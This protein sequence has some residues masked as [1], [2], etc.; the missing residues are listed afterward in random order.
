[1]PKKLNVA[2]MKDFLFLHVE[3]IVLG[4]C[5]FLAL[6]VGFMSM[7]RALSAGTD[8][9]GIPFAEALKRRHDQIA[10]GIRGASAKPLPA[11][12]EAKLK[13]PFYDWEY[14]ESKFGSSLYLWVPDFAND[15]RDNPQPLTIKQG[16]KDIQLDYVRSLVLAYEYD[17]NQR[18]VKGLAPDTSGAGPGGAGPGVPGGKKKEPMAR[19]KGGKADLPSF[20]HAG[21]PQRMVICTALFPMRQQVEEFRRKLRMK[22]QA[23]LLASRGD[24]PRPL[25]IQV[26]RYEVKPDGQPG[27]K[28]DLITCELRDGKVQVKLAEPLKRLLRDSLY[29]EEVAVALEPYLWEG[30]TVP[31]P[32]LAYGSYP[33]IELP[34][35]EVDLSPGDTGNAGAGKAKEGPMGAKK[36]GPDVF[37]P[38]REK[39]GPM[40]QPNPS[41]GPNTNQ[42]ELKMVPI[43]LK[44]LKSANAPLAER[45]FG[46]DLNAFHALG[47]HAQAQQA[48]GDVPKQPMNLPANPMKNKGMAGG[49]AGDPSRFISAWAIAGPEKGEGED[50]KEQPMG[51][52]LPM[53]QGAEQNTEW[54]RDAIV[55]FIDPDVE[56]GKTYRYAIQ[57]RMRNPNFNK[58]DEV[59]FQQLAALEELRLDPIQSW[60][61]TP[62]ITI[63]YEYSLYAL[64]QH[65]LD[66]W[67]DNKKANPLEAKK[68][69]TT[70]QVHQWIPKKFNF[71][72]DDEYVIG[73]WAIAEWLSVRKGDPIGLE[74]VVQVPVWRKFKD[75]FEIPNAIAF[76]FAKG[77]AILKP[78]IKIDLMPTVQDANNTRAATPPVLVD[79]F[80]GKHKVGNV[81]EDAAV[82]ALVMGPDGRLFVVNSREHSDTSNP[83]ARERQ[84]RLVNARKRV[85]D[86]TPSFD[87]STGGVVM[88]GGMK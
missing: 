69:H 11:E 47:L 53:G 44:D 33:K 61:K 22:N 16:P 7:L 78:G 29:D 26:I 64:D 77:N 23:E 14:W 9:S 59:A 87:N 84:E 60:V 27:N 50:K 83:V 66:E 17:T 4:V 58:K 40:Q 1:M 57:V 15:K 79:F 19:D 65:L 76:K 52:K 75:A 25:G 31:A 56:P 55:R 42:P 72:S 32:K 41:V 30:L 70:F 34:G 81:S 51:A 86:L 45:L 38:G 2:A 28:V 35:V 63:P 85:E 24:L 39:K 71:A 46:G 74:A 10:N 13:P 20:L 88:P 49:N 3:K 8:K 12:T 18:T 37:F 48:G 62:D 21:Q 6:C 82:D 43:T 54:D 67:T 36:K 5:V 73:D 80:G 68:D